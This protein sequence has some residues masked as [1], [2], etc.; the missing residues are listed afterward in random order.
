MSHGSLIEEKAPSVV[1]TGMHDWQS[2]VSTPC[3]LQ[4]GAKPSALYREYA[5]PQDL[6]RYIICA[7]TLEISHSDQHHQQRV[8]ADG[9]SDFVWIGDASPVV[10]GPVTRSTLSTTEAGTT[11][12]GLR[13]R[14]EAAARVLGVAAHELADRCIPL[15]EVW[16]RRVV[17]HVCEQL[18]EQRTTAGRLAIVQQFAASWHDTIGAP[19]A[20]VQHTVSLLCA[21][22]RER[23]EELAK[24]VG[25]SERHLRRRFVA[26]VGYSPKVFHRIIR[27]QRLLTLANASRPT[28]LH[29]LAARAGYADQA[30]MTRDVSEF[31]GVTPSALLGKVESAL[32]LSG[33]LREERR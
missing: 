12:V 3:T 13:F 33:M 21:A 30:H 6:R 7:W 5:P 11:L 2:L 10:M 23:V 1:T 27:F 20:A 15:N 8:L 17:D 18:W 4:V 28:R 24:Q 19:D 9:C 32:A 14:P 25:I 22:R 29:I 26:S 16:S 31:A